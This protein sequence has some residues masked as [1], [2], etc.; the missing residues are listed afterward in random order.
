MN[1]LKN[2]PVPLLPTM[3]GAMTLSNVYLTFGFTA[4]RHITMIAGAIIWLL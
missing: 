3:V 1:R 2:M 4:L